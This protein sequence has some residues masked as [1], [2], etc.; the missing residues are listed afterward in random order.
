MGR[1]PDRWPVPLDRAREPPPIRRGSVTEGVAGSTIA[2]T[3]M[4][5]IV[6][7]A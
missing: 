5:A 3:T 2:A 4:P 7:A 1:N 6:S